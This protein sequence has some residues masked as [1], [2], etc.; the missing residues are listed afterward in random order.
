MTLN[1]EILFSPY[2]GT[3]LDPKYKN[4]NN[5]GPKS[6]LNLK[7]EHLTNLLGLYKIFR[8]LTA[9][10][11]LVSGSYSIDKPLHVECFT[12]SKWVNVN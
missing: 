8:N 4:K 6:H 1:F 3:E 12:H 2:F 7:K 5:I 10:L 11:P 9:W